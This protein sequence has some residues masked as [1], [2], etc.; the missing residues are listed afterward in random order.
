MAS[1][2]RSSIAAVLAVL[3]ALAAVPQLLSAAEPARPEGVTRWNTEP[4]G[5][6][7]ALDQNQYLHNMQLHGYWPL[8][9]RTSH[10]WTRIW[11]FDGHRYLFHYVGN[12]INVYDVTDA[13]HL[14]VVLQKEYSDGTVIGASSI[15]WNEQL[16]KWIMVQSFSVPRV[17]PGA[18]DERKWL[19]PA[20][21][22]PHINLPRFR[23]FRVFEL[24]GPT[25]WKLLA[26]VSTD[27]GDPKRK[28][29]GGSGVMDMA[30]YFGGRYAIMAAAP[31]NS[32]NV[33]ESANFYYS[34]AQ[35][36]Y[37]LEDPSHPRL[38]STWWVPGQRQGEIAA[39]KWP[40]SGD[41]LS[42]IGA[43]MSAELPVPLE[44]GGRY[45]YALQGALGLHVL[46][47]KNP[48]RPKSVGSVRTPKPGIPIVGYEGDNVDATR[49]LSRGLVLMN[50]LADPGCEDK[51]QN[52]YPDIFIADVS[53]PRRPAILSALP[54]PPIPP[55]ASFDAFCRRGGSPGP[56]RPTPFVSPGTADPNITFY[57]H[58]S[59]GVQMYDISDAQAPRSAGYFV[60]PMSWD[61]DQVN[62]VNEYDRTVEAIQ[63]EWDRK[64]VW[65]I[66][67]NGVY[68][69]S[70][71]AWGKPNFG[72]P[73][74]GPN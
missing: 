63:V 35:M 32:F 25:D 2:R 39:R 37:D 73:T 70:A 72:A 64:L 29:Q 33:Q 41:Q 47:L 19:D 54:R 6:P 27:G 71:P 49:V 58:G 52:G 11:D 57:A 48:A 65:A 31:D 20:L 42:W 59:A 45:A 15:G 26:E 40:E 62:D 55:G 67:V 24:L 61:A 44:R 43:R 69:L 12:R 17:G 30:T 16:R 21:I 60:P 74:F 46:D 53:N 13:K 10:S 23:G 22:E 3:L 9:V 5:Q 50:G 36:I 1:N 8:V 7:P 34:P 68:L 38:V 4:Y 28:V 66:S 56:K 18:F 51:G 14:K